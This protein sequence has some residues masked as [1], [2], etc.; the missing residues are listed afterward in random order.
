MSRSWFSPYSLI[1]STR[2][3]DQELTMLS[4]G[5]R[6][7]TLPVPYVPP[8]VSS[9]CCTSRSEAPSPSVVTAAPSSQAFPLSDPASTLRSPSPR[10]PSSAPT[11]VP[12][13]VTVSAT[14]SSELSSLRSRRSSRRC[15]RSRSRARRRNKC[16]F[17]C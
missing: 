3:Y 7:A 12:D 4:V 17:H 16:N 1:L 13:A 10:R 2:P 15:S 6:E 14:V 11:V 9:A 8:V 5:T